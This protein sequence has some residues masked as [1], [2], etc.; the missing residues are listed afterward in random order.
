[1]EN[2]VNIW[3]YF[4]YTVYWIFWIG[5]VYLGASIKEGIIIGAIAFGIWF[6]IYVILA[7]IQTRTEPPLFKND[8]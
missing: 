1:M 7:F 5:G 2:L 3:G 6:V 4:G 8:K